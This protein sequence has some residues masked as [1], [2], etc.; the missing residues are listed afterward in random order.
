MTVFTLHEAGLLQSIWS[1]REA[2][3]REL[4]RHLALHPDA[5]RCEMRVYEYV[6]DEPAAY[7]AEGKLIRP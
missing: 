7:F 5:R 1:T 6:V 2:A 4:K 3:E